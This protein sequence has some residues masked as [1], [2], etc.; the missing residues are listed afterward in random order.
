MGIT[1]RIIAKR[2][3]EFNCYQKLKTLLQPLKM[4]KPTQAN[5]VHTVHSPAQFA[6]VSTFIIY[7]QI[8]VH[9]NSAQTYVMGAPV[10]RTKMG[11][12]PGAYS[13]MKQSEMQAL[14]E[15]AEKKRVGQL[16][17]WLNPKTSR[18]M[19][20]YPDHHKPRLVVWH[21]AGEWITNFQYAH[22][23]KQLESKPM[24]WPAVV[25]LISNDRIQIYALNLAA[26]E[27]P[28]AQTRLYCPPFA[29]VSVVGSVCMGSM[30]RPK[31]QAYR[32]VDELAQAWLNSF[33][34]SVGNS[35]H[36]K[37]IKMLS[38]GRSLPDLWVE[39][40]EQP[41]KKRRFPS[42]LLLPTP[43]KENQ[44]VGDLL[45]LLES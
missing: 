22:K 39:L 42:E 34:S 5:N 6:P 40:Q 30:D 41:E 36:S 8:G 43:D 17:R 15:L 3:D 20:Y 26:G 7:Q 32:H 9:P 10:H 19:G 44:T 12:S 24:A 13:P 25:A 11:Y 37:G 23:G 14:G 18:V 27:E 29:N 45:K 1:K 2:I 16:P 21:P 33:F 38:D 35:D 28:T 4:D 31:P